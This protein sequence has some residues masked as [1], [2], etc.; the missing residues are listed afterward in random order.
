MKKIIIL[1]LL[2]LVVF[3]VNTSYGLSGHLSVKPSKPSLSLNF[4]ADDFVKLSPKQ[5]FE[6]TGRKLNLFQKLSFK[7]LKLKMKHDL[8]KNP[9]LTLQDYEGD[10][11]KKKLGTGWVILIV[12]GVL[13]LLVLLV[14]GASFSSAH[15]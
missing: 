12:V 5:Y 3:T 7:V 14:V 6:L 4:K 2:N 1:L 10:E 8:K 13:L 9:N 11:A 15:W